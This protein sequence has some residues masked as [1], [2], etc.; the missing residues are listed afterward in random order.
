MKTKTFYC[1]VSLLTA[2]ILS[3]S[4]SETKTAQEHVS[5]FAHA[6]RCDQVEGSTSTE[7]WQI[8]KS[9]VVSH[10]DF[11]KNNPIFLREKSEKGSLSLRIEA[12]D[13]QGET[14]LQ[15]SA[16]FEPSNRDVADPAKP[17][18]AKLNI[19]YGNSAI[20]QSGRCDATEDAG[21]YVLSI[22]TKSN[23]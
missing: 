16:Q 15:V 23:D 10:I 6:T 20:A 21:S 3:A 1:L 14:R 12:L 8:G 9:I 18:T 7:T 4:A 2:P 13:V 5:V 19:T 17:S 11:A 22:S